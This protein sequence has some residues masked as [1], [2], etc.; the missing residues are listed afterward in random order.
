MSTWHDREFDVLKGKTIKLVELILTTRD[1]YSDEDK[2]ETSGIRFITKDNMVVDF[3]AYGDCCSTSFI[4][5]LDNPT[6]FKD[7]IF[8]SVE[9]IE[10][11]NKENAEF[12]VHKWTF[13]KF[14]TSKG[15]CTLSFRNESNGYYDGFLERVKKGI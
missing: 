6:I 9:S 8:E 14:K 5:S 10:G 12:D 7:A 4:E 15:A 2:R 3:R 1:E 11:E 13:Y